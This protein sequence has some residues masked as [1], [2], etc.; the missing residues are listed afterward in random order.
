MG[1]GTLNAGSIGFTSG[2]NTKRHELT[3]STGIVKV[4]GDVTQSGSTGSATITFT[5]AG[6]LQLGGAFLTSTTGTLIQSTGTVE[7]NAAGAQTVGDFAYNNLTLSGSGVKTMPATVTVSGNLTLNGTA[8]ATTAAAMTIGNLNVGAGT[9]FATGATNTW[10]LTVSGTTSVGGTL[11]LANTANKTFT[12]NVIVNNGG[13]WN[14]TG[15]AAIGYAGNLQN[16]G[17]YTANTGVHT[18]SGAGKTIGGANAIAVPN[19]TISGTTTN[20]G[21]LTVSTALAGASTLTNGA[22]GSLSFGGASITPTLVASTASNTVNYNGGA[23]TVKAT[24]YANLV[25]SGSA[26][27]TIATGTSVS[28]NLSIAPTGS[29]TANITAGL[30]ISVGSLKLGGADQIYGTW[31]STTSAATNK[32]NTYFAATTGILT[33]GKANLT[34]TANNTGKTYGQALTFAGTEFTH[35]TLFGTDSVTGVTLTSSG[36]AATA[37]VAGSPYS[38]VPSAA[39]GSG[40]TNYIITYINGA[41][42]V[43][44]KALSITANSTS[45]TYGQTVTFAGT[46]FTQLGLVNSDT[47]SSVTLVSTGAVATAGVAGSPY[48][49]VPS[50]ATGSGLNNYAISYNNGSLTVTVKAATVVAD[51]KS[52]AYGDDNPTLSAIPSGTVNGDTLNYTLATTAVKFSNVGGYPI[53]VT[54]GSNPNYTV[55]KT[56]NTLSI[57]AKAAT[58][59]A[60][61][62]SKTY[63][64]DNP[65]LA[66]TVVGAVNGDVIN[67]TLATDALKFSGVG[68]YP[69]T[70]TL[71]SNSA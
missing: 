24:A 17:T 15:A 49:I 16:D 41:L 23:Q 68:S 28:G 2:G 4:T 44:Q 18:F 6:L 63:G 26:A 58:V 51:P 20:N 8:T 1:A 19:L 33:V 22:T 65:A 55:T 42:T 61:P 67:Y 60:D 21:A 14:E 11:T 10:T 7:Y 66:A 43:N 57:G 12:G 69:I 71:G 31:G 34:I 59:M 64:D 29:A 50:A 36:A 39:T 32:N 70:V 54:L 62:K 9:T 25:F 46:E 56:D 27:K 53:T 5:G 3:I 40:L 30:N 37:D 48:S 38:I 45:K 47:V 52:K 13:T 35:S